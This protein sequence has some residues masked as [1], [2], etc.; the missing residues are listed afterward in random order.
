VQDTHHFFE[1]I[2]AMHKLMDLRDKAEAIDVEILEI[3]VRVA[4][5]E[6]HAHAAREG[7]CGGD[8]ATLGAA[9]RLVDAVATLMGRVVSRVTKDPRV[10]NAY[11]IFYA[12]RGNPAKVT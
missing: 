2:N 1:A 8:G 5:R 3:L 4:V 10:W 11:A 6:L 12:G 9:H 7:G